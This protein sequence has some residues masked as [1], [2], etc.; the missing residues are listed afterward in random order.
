MGNPFEEASLMNGK[1]EGDKLEQIK[2]EEKPVEGKKE[3]KEKIENKTDLKFENSEDF[4]KRC[5]SRTEKIV[6]KEG[7]RYKLIEF[8]PQNGEVEEWVKDRV[9]YLFGGNGNTCADKGIPKEDQQKYFEEISANWKKMY[10]ALKENPAQV[11]A[12]VEEALNF[13][14]GFLKSIG[15]ESSVNYYTSALCGEQGAYA[16]K[17]MMENGEDMEEKTSEMIDQKK[18]LWVTSQLSPYTPYISTLFLRR[19]I[20]EMEEW[21]NEFDESYKNLVGK[22]RLEFRKMH[23]DEEVAIKEAQNSGFILDAWRNLQALAYSRKDDL[24]RPETISYFDSYREPVS[25]DKY[26]FSLMKFKNK[27]IYSGSA[28]FGWTVPARSKISDI[29]DL[30]MVTGKE[31]YD[32]GVF[33]F[34]VIEHQ[35]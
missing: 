27:A 2:D 28:G 4:I 10:G 32:E 21:K 13:I 26:A 1:G 17:K 24:Y 3:V 22:D 29:T 6:E 20:S 35:L 12:K 11:I 15:K 34:M 5:F 33:K 31:F 19:D 25:D 8:H 7:L 30:A 18:E 14:D 9:F 16:A 23:I